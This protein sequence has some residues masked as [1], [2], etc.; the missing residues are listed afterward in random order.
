MIPVY[1]NDR[2]IGMMEPVAFDRGVS[3]ASFA[4]LPP[5]RF[6]LTADELVIPPAIYRVDLRV[7]DQRRNGVPGELHASERDLPHLLNLKNFIPEDW[8]LPLL[9]AAAS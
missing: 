9:R 1:Y 7:E 3:W 8:A 2:Q 4:I 6:P 5:V